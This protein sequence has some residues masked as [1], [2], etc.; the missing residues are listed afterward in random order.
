MLKAIIFDI[1]GVIFPYQPWIGERPPHDE[2]MKIKQIAIDIYDRCKISKKCLLEEI[3]KADRPKAELEAIFKSLTVID[4]DLFSLIKNLSEKYRLF[5]IANEAPKWTDIRK[6]IYDFEKYFEKLYI[7]IEV[8]MRKPDE[9]IFQLFLDESGLKPE[10][11]LFIDDKQINIDTAERLG[12]HGHLYTDV[13][14]LVNLFKELQIKI[15][16]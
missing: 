12:M 15:K 13:E 1:T 5:A 11:C 8:G 14:T 7:S 4:E 6:E 9:N 16:L 10:E 2:L 3:S